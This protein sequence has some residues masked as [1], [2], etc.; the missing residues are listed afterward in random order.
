MK[1]IIL[2]AGY[3][4][5]LANYNNGPK[6]L[7]EVAG[8][9]V[10]EHIVRKLDEIDG[11]D[12][13]YIITNHKFNDCIENWL[14]NFRAKKEI[15]LVD[16]GTTSNENRLGAIGDLEFL[17]KKEK[18]KDD[19]LCIGGDNLFE[20]DLKGFVQFFNNKKSPIVGLYD[21]KNKEEAKRFGVVELHDDKGIV[22]FEEKPENP[23][24]T[25][26]STCAYIYNEKT[27]GYIDIYL[28]R[29]GNRD[30]P[31][32][33]PKWLHKLIKVYGFVF[34]GG[35]EDIGSIESMNRVKESKWKL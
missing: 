17:V 4:T 26:I 16:D 12:K 25:L 27:L 5:R 15:R 29:G 19:I 21:V 10:I 8:K 31:G 14:K 28:K 33:L 7:I 1:S 13:T 11:V 30:A 3:G 20:S 35:W 6:C 32:N 24:S 34:D 22:S 2:A 9:P 23:K 18:I